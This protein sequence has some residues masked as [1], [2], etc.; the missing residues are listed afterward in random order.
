MS[1]NDSKLVTKVSPLIEGQVPDFVQSDHPVFVRFLKHYYQYL[2]AGR[3]TLDT[4]SVEYIIQETATTSYILNSDGDRVVTE[5]GTGTTSNFVENETVTGSTSGATATVLL[6]DLRNNYVY[7]SSQQKFVT[8][9]TITGGTSGATGTIKEY[10]ANPVQ[11]IQQLLEYANTDNT[12]FD[13]LDEFRNSFMN[14]IPNTLASGVSKRNLIKNIK[15]LY[16]AKGTSEGHKLF[17]RLFV[18]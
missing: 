11:N 14:A 13:F 2:E 17:M 1:K 10:R 16:A 8:G 18:G 9:E 4:P 3:I 7:I 15:D 12:I 6:Q 5:K